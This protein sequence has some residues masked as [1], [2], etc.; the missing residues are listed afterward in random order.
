MIESLIMNTK[1]PT[2]IIAR[3]VLLHAQLVD[4]LIHLKNM[5]NM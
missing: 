4:A 5:R 1:L 2:I 3:E